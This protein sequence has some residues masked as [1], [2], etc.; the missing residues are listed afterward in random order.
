MKLPP[1][2]QSQDEIFNS[3]RTYLVFVPTHLENL[4]VSN[5]NIQ[6]VKDGKLLKRRFKNYGAEI[7]ISSD[8]MLTKAEVVE[9]VRS[10]AVRVSYVDIN[11]NPCQKTVIIDDKLQ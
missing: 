10:D 8:G 11:G 6:E 7:N 3:I 2:P 9:I 5:Y 1:S 4:F